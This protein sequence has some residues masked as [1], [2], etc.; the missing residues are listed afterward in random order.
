[1][2]KKELQTNILGEHTLEKCSNNKKYFKPKTTLSIE[3]PSQ[4]HICRQNTD[5]H[6]LYTHKR[7]Y[8]KTTR[9]LAQIKYVVYDSYYVKI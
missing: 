6:K 1:M 8:T 2:E 9:C 4:R 7:K 3:A 5:A